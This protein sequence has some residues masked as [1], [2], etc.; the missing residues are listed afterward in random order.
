VRSGLAVRAAEVGARWLAEL[1]AI[2]PV[3]GRG[4]MIGVPLKDAAHAL[5]VSRALLER[6]YIVLTGGVRGD[7]L[8]LSPSLI[9][10]P[11]LLSAFSRAL[12][13]AV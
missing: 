4:L 5:A 12:A 1:E 3:R 10:A 11:E 7:V 6:G 2:V 13:A 9:I 8:T